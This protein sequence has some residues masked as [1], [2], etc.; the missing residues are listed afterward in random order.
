MKILFY[1]KVNFAIKGNSGIVNKINAQAKAFRELGFECD[2]VYFENNNIVIQSAED[3]KEVFAF[4]SKLSRIRFQYFGFL[5]KI[6]LQTYDLLYVRHFSLQPL[7]YNTLKKIKFTHS[8]IKIIMEIP[9]YPYQ[10]ELKNNSVKQFIINQLDIFYWK[11][12]PSL[13]DRVLT[14]SDFET[15]HQIPTLKTSNGIDI[16]SFSAK[17]KNGLLDEFHLLGLANV[18]RWHGFDRIIEGMKIWYAQKDQKTNSLKNIFFHIVGDGDAIA[19]LK[20][21][22]KRYDLEKQVIFHGAKFGNELDVFFQQC[23]IA[24]NSLAWHRTGANSPTIKMREYCARGIPFINGYEDKDLPPNFPFSFQ[25]ASNDDAIEI[26]ALI[27]F[28]QNIEQKHA[29]YPNFLHNF[30]KNNLTWKAKLKVV[31]DFLGFNSL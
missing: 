7:I 10:L 9:T 24:A 19:E 22:T 27:A 2:L 4:S 1:T 29:D 21:L 13:I 25:V 16:T 30:A 17:E 5:K 28:F 11:K 20:Q 3:K 8:R 26:N 12:M 23:H 31:A 18:Q 6:N 14:F 15:I